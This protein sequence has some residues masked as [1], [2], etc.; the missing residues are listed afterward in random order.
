MKKA[1]SDE[2]EKSFLHKDA[3]VDALQKNANKILNAPN[4]NAFEALRNARLKPILFAA[5]FAILFFMSGCVDQSS[6]QDGGISEKFGLWWGI[7]SAPIAAALGIGIA[8]CTLSWFYASFMQDD[9]LK[10]WVKSEII[11]LG[12]TAL[13]LMGIL[14]IVNSLGIICASLPTYNTLGDSPTING[15]ENIG[16]KWSAYVN[17]RCY[18]SDSGSPLTQGKERPCHIIIAEDYLNILAKSTEGQALSIVRINAILYPLSTAGFGFK[19]IPA[20]GGALSVSPLAGLTPVVETLSFVFDVLMKNLM[21]TRAQQFIIDFMHL[22]F[23]PFFLAAGIFFRSMYFTRRLGGLL[24]ALAIGFY[25]VFPMMYV[26]WSSVLYSFTGP[27]N[28]TPAQIE[29][30][31]YNI[32]RTDINFEGVERDQ[33]QAVKGAPDYSPLCKNGEIDEGEECGEY[34]LSCPPRDE[35]GNTISGRET[36]YYCNE[37]SCRCTSDMNTYSNFRQEFV[38]EDGLLDEQTKMIVD[39]CYTKDTGEDEVNSFLEIKR[40]S[41]EKRLWQ[42][43]SQ[44][45]ADAVGPLVGVGAVAGGGYS[46]FGENGTID[47]MAKL[48]IFSLIAPFIS[49]MVALASIKVLSPSLGG[50]IEIAG[51]SRLI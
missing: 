44:G 14:M 18:P 27:W 39:I 51:L 1:K 9:K 13:I 42:G 35:Y 46:L 2:N 12:Y 29:Q 4:L 23:F 33:V 38:N 47:N 15:V 10:A 3:P 36:D 5:M 30:I 6:G 17:A 26:F 22:A 28:S 32:Y 37:N 40:E 24:I 43:Y 21:I 48:L 20:P 31:G 7:W 49:L 25:I 8:I 41:W 16:L 34:G 11:Q 19:G 45:F 50:D